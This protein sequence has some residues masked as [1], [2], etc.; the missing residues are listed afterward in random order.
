[1]HLGPIAY[2]L[3]IVLPTPSH[4]T[5]APRH[6]W[7]KFQKHGAEITRISTTQGAESKEKAKLYTGREEKTKKGAKAQEVRLALP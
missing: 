4:P 5:Y 2:G 1:M 6:A 7:S 3:W